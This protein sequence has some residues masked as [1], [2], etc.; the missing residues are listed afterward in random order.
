MKSIQSLPYVQYTTEQRDLLNSPVVGFVI[1]NV[2]KGFYETYNGD[3]WNRGINHD[4]AY[5]DM[6][7]EF[8]TGIAG[9]NQ[10]TVGNIG[11][12]LFPTQWL[13]NNSND[14]FCMKAQSPHSRRQHSAIADI[15][16]HYIL[17][18]NYTANQSILFDVFYTW[19]MPD[20]VVADLQNWITVSNIS[21][22]MTENKT[23]LYNGIFSL[24][25]NINPPINEGYGVGILYRIVRKNGT[26]SGDLGI[27][28]TDLHIIKDKTGSKSPIND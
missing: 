20:S 7:G 23:A 18:T 3:L 11:D 13:K 22:I 24:I 14:F 28:W 15:H 17:Q 6:M 26:Y 8:L 2:T 1:F 21:L 19:I 25:V 10:W 12:T 27:L 4:I 16:I 9:A 5:D